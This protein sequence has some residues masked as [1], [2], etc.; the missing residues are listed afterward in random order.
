[1]SMSEPVGTLAYIVINTRDQNVAVPFWQVVLGRAV[2]KTEFPFT[3]L[4]AP[5]ELT[6]S[7][8]QVEHYR[9]GHEIH[10]D[11]RVADLEAAVAEVE[12]LG[13]RLVKRWPD[14]WRCATMSDP[15]GN[16]FCLV[17]E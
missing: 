2:G 15:D 16:H 11:L 1:M 7:I 5:G 14:D 13:G 8:Q 10:I 17:V 9:G 3:D 12:R 6:V 4:V